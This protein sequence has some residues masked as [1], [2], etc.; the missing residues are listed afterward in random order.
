MKVTGLFS[1]IGGFE[2]GFEQ[3]GF[4]ISM[5]VDIDPAA[6]AV[7]AGHFPDAEVEKDVFALKAFADGTEVVTAGF[8][9]QDLSMAGSKAGIEGGRSSVVTAMVALLEENSV[10]F[11]VFENV[12]FMLHLEKGTAMRWLTRTLEDLD[13]KWA[14]RVLD[15]MDFGLPQ[16]RRRVYLVA[17][18][19]IDPRGVLFCESGSREDAHAPSREVPLGFYWTEG[20]SGV[21]FTV[22]GIPPLKVG[23]AVGIPS[24]PAVLFPDG[25]V[26]TPGITA[27]E[28]LQG[29]EPD[30]TDATMPLH[31]RGVRWRLVGNSVSVPV[32]RWVASRLLNPGEPLDLDERPID[33]GERWPNAAWNVGAGPRR[34]VENGRYVDSQRS[35]IEAFRDPTWSMLSDRALDGFIERAKKGGLNMPDWFLDA[36]VAADR[37][38]TSSS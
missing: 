29:F 11:V 32:A 8:P 19:E 21:G 23:S 18:R 27:C 31:E 25:A 9:C 34:V 4:E 33:P 15:T 24:P 6:R 10:P 38:P 26:L 36:L 3:A 35:G 1:G 5:M 2:L 20:K 13:Y 17:C 22:D 16:R 14:Y 28:K 7:L 30:W 37:K 12:P